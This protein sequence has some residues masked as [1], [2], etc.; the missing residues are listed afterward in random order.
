MNEKSSNI[1]KQ[2]EPYCITCVIGL[3]R[4]AEHGAVRESSMKGAELGLN[5]EGWKDFQSKGGRG[6]SGAADE[7]NSY[8]QLA[9]L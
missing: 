3:R 1:S 9:G 5:L 2:H 6:E 4:S 7:R 8:E